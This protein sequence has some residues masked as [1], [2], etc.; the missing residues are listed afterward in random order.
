M[1]TSETLL[2]QSPEEILPPPC[3]KRFFFGK[4]SRSSSLKQ[5]LVF[6]PKRSIPKRGWVYT[7]WSHIE[8]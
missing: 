7:A 2:C 4:Y 1:Y 8:M 3:K 5:R 6:F